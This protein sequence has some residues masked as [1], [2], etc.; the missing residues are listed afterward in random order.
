MSSTAR[1]SVTSAATATASWPARRSSAAVSRP[2]TAST[3]ATMTRAPAPANAA[4]NARPMPCPA[5]VMMLTFPASW[6]EDSG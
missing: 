1:S 3:S 6:R 2:A 4:A 5:P